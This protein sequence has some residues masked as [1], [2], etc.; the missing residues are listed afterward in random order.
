M[1]LRGSRPP[2]DIHHDTAPASSDDFSPRAPCVCGRSA[3][4]HTPRSV[5]P[6]LPSKTQPL[7]C[8][9]HNSARPVVVFFY[10]GVTENG[11]PRPRSNTSVS[12]PHLIRPTRTAAREAPSKPC[13]R[14]S[15]SR[16]AVF[17]PTLATLFESKQA[18]TNT[19]I[20]KRERDRH[21]PLLPSF[22]PVSSCYIGNDS[23]Y[24]DSSFFYSNFFQ[25]RVTSAGDAPRDG[26]TREPYHLPSHFPLCSVG[27]PAA[28]SAASSILV[29][30]V[31]A[32]ESPPP[33]LY[34]KA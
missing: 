34:I 25:E 10:F 16:A 27:M 3:N 32:R 14:P 19:T 20:P 29:P 4:R 8:V 2:C 22:G 33:F 1:S 28:P 5:H 15:L 26:R 23:K 7:F 12:S 31:G 18:T 17:A 13:R 9:V 6:K 30:Q 11:Q 21:A 24:Y